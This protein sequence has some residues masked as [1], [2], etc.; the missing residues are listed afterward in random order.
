M[1]MVRKLA[2]SAAAAGLLNAA[3]REARKP[4]NQR[5]AKELLARAQSEVKA[6]RTARRP[7]PRPS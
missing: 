7:T 2:R 1:G 6:R 5:R 4:E 3:M